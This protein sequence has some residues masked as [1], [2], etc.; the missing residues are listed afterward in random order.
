MYQLIHILMIDRYILINIKKERQESR[1][2]CVGMR[3]YPL[4]PTLTT[5][6]LVPPPANTSHTMAGYR[7]TFI[8]SWLGSLI[9]VVLSEPQKY[10][11]RIWNYISRSQLG[12]NMLIMGYLTFV[13]MLGNDF[14]SSFQK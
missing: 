13:H 10:V 9:V 8:H 4:P 2:V 12:V 6:R 3:D 1:G 7:H 14:D 11:K 5:T